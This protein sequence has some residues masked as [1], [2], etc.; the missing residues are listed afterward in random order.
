MR[1]RRCEILILF[2]H[3]AARERD[4]HADLDTVGIE[5]LLLHHWQIRAGGRAVGRVGI[6][7]LAGGLHAWVGQLAGEPLTDVRAEGFSRVRASA[8]TDT[9]QGLQ[10]TCGSG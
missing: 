7:A 5:M 9:A 6:G 1:E 4:Q 10:A 8:P 2:F 3:A